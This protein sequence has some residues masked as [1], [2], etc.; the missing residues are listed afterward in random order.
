MS[1]K[2]TP[3]GKS[4]APSPGSCLPSADD[5]VTPLVGGLN[6]QVID[7]VMRLVNVFQCAVT[8]SM[9]ESVIFP[10]RDVAMR[11]VEQ[12]ERSVIPSC[13]AKVCINRWMIIQILPVV[14]RSVLDFPDCLVDLGNGVLFFSVHPSRVSLV[15]QMRSRLAQI[16]KRME[17]CGMVLSEAHRDAKSGK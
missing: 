3:S 8:Q 16:S 17:V 9:G 6:N 5:S 15:F 13:A 12:F 14:N 10:F 11:L 4:R 2:T 1:Q 7:D